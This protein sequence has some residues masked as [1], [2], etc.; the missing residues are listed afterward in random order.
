MRREPELGLERRR[1]R[2]QDRVMHAIKTQQDDLAARDGASRFRPLRRS[3]G[4]EPKVA[5]RVLF[6]SFNYPPQDGGVSRLC[7]EL[8]SG[9][10]RKG[11][12]IQV[13]SQRRNGAGSCIPSAPEERVTMRR[14]WREL[15]A[16]R[17]LRRTGPNLAIICG[18][19]YPEG[20]LAT[21]AGAR[22]RVILVHGLELRPT[23][24]RWRRRPWRWLM[25][26]VLR[27]ASLVVANS[28]YTAGLVRARAPGAV[29]AALPLGVD[30]RR[31]CPGDQH[32]AR[33][34][35]H[36][37]DEKRVIVTTSRILLYKG[38]RLV[39]QALAA[40]PE[41]IRNTFIYLIAGQGR[42]MSRLQH[43]AEA[44]GLARVVRWLGYVP[45]AD[46]PELYRSADLFALCTREDHDQPDVEGFGLAFLE[47]Q[48][49][50]IP[51][52]G[53]RTGGIPDAVSEG[54]GG[55]L[56]GQDDLAALTA[57]LARLVEAPEN[58][59]QMGQTARQRVES[60]CTWERYMDR[61]IQVL[62]TRG[63]PIK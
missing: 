26:F 37:P 46:L 29:M 25:Q 34:R 63:V 51:V 6:F 21:L 2:A 54:R 30:H 60:E 28:N 4:N 32:A 35:L 48:A 3:A 36:V 40:L 13:L 17:R 10:Q 1:Q 8:V 14:P 11:V 52:V 55:W 41:P 50:G 15:A 49:C 39:F 23:R 33:R 42:D 43:D 57:I 47:A 53:T 22:P 7:A 12:A 18:L 56:I 61:L 59:R 58:F 5:C 38:H 16:V 31:F 24:E 62:E 19:W 27:R 20:L 9:F 44:L 45:E